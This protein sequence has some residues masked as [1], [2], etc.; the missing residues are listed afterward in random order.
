LSKK[1]FFLLATNNPGS[2]WLS[3]GTFFHHMILDCWEQISVNWNSQ[4]FKIGEERIFVFAFEVY[5]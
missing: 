2:S 1:G 5:D 3:A 4:I